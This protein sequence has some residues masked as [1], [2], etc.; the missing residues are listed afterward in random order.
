M[1]PAGR[2]L[3]KWRKNNPKRHRSFAEK[4]RRMDITLSK[5]QQKEI[6]D[7]LERIKNNEE[8]TYTLEELKEFLKKE[9]FTDE[10]D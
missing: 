4:R 6:A 5:D 9:E 3:T 2:T 1:K 8:K 7:M 10:T